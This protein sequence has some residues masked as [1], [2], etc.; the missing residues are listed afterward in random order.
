[1]NEPKENPD[2]MSLT[3]L[4]AGLVHEIRNPLS[5]INLNLQLLKEDWQH[6]ETPQDKRALRKLDVIQSETQRLEVVLNDILRFVRI[7]NLELEPHSM[8]AMLDEIVEFKAGE[9]RL[10]SIEVVKFYDYNLPQCMADP[11]LLKQ[12]LLNILMNAQ[13]AVEQD[14]QIMIRTSVDGGLARIEIMDTGCGMAPD[15][16][17]KIFQ[18]WFSTKN[19]G[20][21]LGLPT[22]K[23]IIEAHGGSIEVR[24]EPGRGTSVVVRLR[25]DGTREMG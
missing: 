21:G 1:M 18:P 7:E 22:T 24:S 13:Q 25:P 5:T 3:S 8:N 11:N 14:G 23:R 4:V 20:T 12:A 2:C 16:L 6:A 10:K 15:V 17:A 19:T 9:L